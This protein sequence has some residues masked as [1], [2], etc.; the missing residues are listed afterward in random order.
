MKKSLAHLP[1]YKRDELQ[2]VKEIILDECPTEFWNS[3]DAMEFWGRHTQF[4][5]EISKLSPEFH[6]FHRGAVNC[7]FEGWPSKSQVTRSRPP[8]M[9]CPR[10]F[11]RWRSCRT[12]GIPTA[13][14][15]VRMTWS[16]SKPRSTYPPARS[17]ARSPKT[18]CARSVSRH[19]NRACPPRR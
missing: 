14:R 8:K 17:T 15:T 18:C 10:T 11:R 19:A 3:G 13:V 12:S 9:S 5:I 1:K 2:R 7:Y 16:R 4:A 6:E